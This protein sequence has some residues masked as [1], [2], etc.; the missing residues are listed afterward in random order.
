MLNNIAAQLYKLV[1]SRT[2]ERERGRE[3]E[4]ER[5][6]VQTDRQRQTETD[7]YLALTVQDVSPP[8]RYSTNRV[9]LSYRLVSLTKP[10]T[11]I[12]V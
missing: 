1:Q 10:G 8:S 9:M 4:R 6:R 5:E 3:R 7:D 12:I 11:D 2:R